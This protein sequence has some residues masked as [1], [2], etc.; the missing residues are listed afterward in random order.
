MEV[1]WPSLSLFGFRLDQ[2]R[3]GIL[4]CWKGVTNSGPL[5]S[6]LYGVRE[7][8]RWPLVI[9]LASVNQPVI[10][11]F[12]NRNSWGDMSLGYHNLIQYS[13]II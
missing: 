4:R 12:W 2:V 6:G 5:S 8:I 9:F 10:F 7:M 1:P 13:Q 3:P 11:Q